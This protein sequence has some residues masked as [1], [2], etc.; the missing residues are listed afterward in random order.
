MKENVVDDLKET[1]ITRQGRDIGSF[2]FEKF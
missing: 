2:S 1:K